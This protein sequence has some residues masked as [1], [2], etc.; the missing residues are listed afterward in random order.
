MQN[1]ILILGNHQYDYVYIPDVELNTTQTKPSR[2]RGY[3]GIQWCDGYGMLLILSVL[4]Y[5]A[6]IYYQVIKP[7]CGRRIYEGALKPAQV[8]ISRVLK[9]R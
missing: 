1:A 6:L 4:T 9:K 2:C 5:I 8:T 7:R 3:C